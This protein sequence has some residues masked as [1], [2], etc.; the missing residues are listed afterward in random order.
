MDADFYLEIL[1]RY[2]LPFIRSEFPLTHRFMQD[3]DPKHTSRKAKCFF[4]DEGINWWQAPPESPDLNPIENLWHELKEYIQREVM[5]TTKTQ[6]IQGIVQFWATVDREKCCRYIGHL[7]KVIPKVIDC[8]GA[9][10]FRLLKRRTVNIITVTIF[11]YKPKLIHWLSL[12]HNVPS[13]VITKLL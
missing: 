9:A 6:L 1:R 12:I 7:N 5:P 13:N 11:L 4:E 8:S 2:L 3:N 10:C